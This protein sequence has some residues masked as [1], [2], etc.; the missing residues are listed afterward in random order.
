MSISDDGNLIVTKSENNQSSELRVWSL[1]Q[2]DVVREIP[3][4]AI[5]AGFTRDGE[6][7][8]QDEGGQLRIYIVPTT[9]EDLRTWA[10]SN[11]SIRGL[12]CDEREQFDV[13][14]LCTD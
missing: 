6:L 13:L 12:T 14:P 9:V 5:Y 8:V 1:Q 10:M 3:I 4:D 11:R 2:M 7:V